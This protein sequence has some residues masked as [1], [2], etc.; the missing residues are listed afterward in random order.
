MKN[1]M[2]KIITLSLAVGMSTALMAKPNIDNSGMHAQM[3]KMAG[4]KGMFVKHEAFPKDYFLISKSLPFAVGLTLHHPRSSELNLSKEQIEQIQ[5]IKGDTIPVVIQAAKKIKALEIALAQ[6]MMEGAKAKDEYKALQE[7]AD[8]KTAL[9]QIHLQ[10]IE[11]VRAT[12]NPQQRKTLLSYAGAKMKKGQKHPIEELVKL[13]HPVKMILMNKESLKITPK[14][15]SSIENEM[16]AVY[17]AKIHGKMDEA[18]LIEDKIKKE[19][20]KHGTTKEDLKKDIQALADMKVQITNDHID[21]LNK[22][23][24]VLTK[25]QY[26]QL[27]NL[28][29]SSKKHH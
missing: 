4:K 19:V 26:K 11:N 5:K 22:L 2:K 10:C 15:M 17:P 8:K 18:K 29:K 14:Q 6:R 13:P 21:A 23:Q 12:L 7:I 24:A 25:E 27:L 3:K 20:L 28:V 1:S 16:L 9:S